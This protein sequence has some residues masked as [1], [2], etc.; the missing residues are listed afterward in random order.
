MW[1]PNVECV[2]DG[3]EVHSRFTSPCTRKQTWNS[4][5]KEMSVI[6]KSP[7]LFWTAYCPIPK[8]ATISLTLI[9]SCL[10]ISSTFCLLR[11]S[12]R[13]SPSTTA[14]LIGDIS[15]FILKTFHT[16]SNIAGTHAG[17]SIHTTKSLVNN[18][19]QV[20]SFT[21]N[22]MTASWRQN[23]SVTAIISQRKTRS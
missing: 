11:S 9:Q 14:Q 21:R 2:V 15:F 19:Y 16:L 4:T 20:R 18:C 8:Y 6:P 5:G 1:W 22:S 3:R 10:L 23:M 17:I 12:S 7:S 13:I